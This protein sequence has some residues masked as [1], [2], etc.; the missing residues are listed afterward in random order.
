M[1]DAPADAEAS[2]H[3]IEFLCDGFY[4]GIS[5]PPG[6]GLHIHTEKAPCDTQMSLLELDMTMMSAPPPPLPT[7]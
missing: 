2:H 7:Q 5:I 6:G 1:A 4:L 3:D